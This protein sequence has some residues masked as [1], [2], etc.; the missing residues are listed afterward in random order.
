MPNTSS[1]TNKSTF[2]KDN[3]TAYDKSTIQ[4]TRRLL[5]NVH[6]SRIHTDYT[7]KVLCLHPKIQHIFRFFTH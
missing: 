3:C 1:N 6:H 7:T 4:I 2:P 5:K